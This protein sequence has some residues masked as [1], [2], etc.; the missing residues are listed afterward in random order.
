MTYFRYLPVSE[1]LE[2]LRL[3]GAD[4]IAAARSVLE[5]RNYST[6]S[7]TFA[8][9]TTETALRCA[10]IAAWHP[11][12][13][14]LVNRSYSF[15]SRMEKVSHLLATDDAGGG[16][17]CAAVEA[18]SGLL[19]RHRRK[20][21]G[22][23]GVITPPPPQFDLELNRPPP[24]VPTK[25]LQSVLLDRV[26]GFYL[27]AIA[28]LPA[29]ELRRRYHRS[30]LKAGHCYGPF[31]DPVSNIVLNTVWYDAIFPPPQDELSSV[32]MI[33][34][35]SLVLVACRSVRGLVAY[36]RACF[37]TISEHQ[38]IRYLVFA[39]VDLWGAIEMARRE[40]HVE[41]S[42]VTV[43]KESACKAAAIA[44]M[45]PDADAVV[46]FHVSTR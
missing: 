13:R 4:P 30:L 41:R 26:Y 45:H 15:A 32:A 16:L 38:A 5:D 3:A 22:L 27:D 12:P 37:D 35:R 23:A 7:F 44:A 6:S 21:R 24:F 40:G 8:S 31:K 14:S 18:I 9:R 42:T 46:N 39:E 36:L 17:S 25:S 19:K 29:A 1:A 11:K 10:A 34:S 43:G 33:C 2:Y 28:R 20:I